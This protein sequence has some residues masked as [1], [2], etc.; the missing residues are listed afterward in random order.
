MPGIDPK[1]FIHEIKTYS[2][3]K[4]I[5][6]ILCPIHPRKVVAIK[7]EVE[8]ILQARFIYPIPLTDWVSNIVPITKKTKDYM[9]MHRL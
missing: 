7:V 9:C 8:K 3:A 2:D 6:K 4:P 5:R 1:I